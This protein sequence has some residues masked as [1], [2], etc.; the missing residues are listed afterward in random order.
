MLVFPENAISLLWEMSYFLI[1][2]FY[3]AYLAGVANKAAVKTLCKAGLCY[4]YAKLLTDKRLTCATNNCKRKRPNQLV[5][6]VH[7]YDILNVLVF[8]VMFL[9]SFFLF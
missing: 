4:K 8:T 6:C 9:L 7:V 3:T 1:K 2:Q 5:P